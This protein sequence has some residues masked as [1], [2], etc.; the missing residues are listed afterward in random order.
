M[1]IEPGTVLEVTTASGATAFMR[2]ISGPTKGRDFPVVWVCTEAE[3]S[4][5]QA[6]GVVAEGIP[7]PLNAVRVPERT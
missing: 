2:A 5:A 6:E 3:H 7:W 4:R 1:E